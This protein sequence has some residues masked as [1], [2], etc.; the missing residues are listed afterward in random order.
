MKLTTLTVAVA[1]ACTLQL[2]MPLSVYSQKRAP[3]IREFLLQYRGKEV[4]ILDKTGNI[5]QFVG[6]NPTKAYVLTLVDVQNDH[7]I[8][9]RDSDTDKRTFIYPISV[10]RRI[11]YL[12]DN[13]PYDRIVIELY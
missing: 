5:E 6:G 4:H 3:T 13:K 8:V 9:S 10:I 12:Y 7:I 1:V 11:I 2:S